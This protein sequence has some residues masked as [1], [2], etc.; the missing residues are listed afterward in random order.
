MR[1]Q[2]QQLINLFRDH[3]KVS[4]NKLPTL[5]VVVASLFEIE[6]S[7]GNLESAVREAR[8]GG[9]FVDQVAKQTGVTIRV[10]SGA[11]EASGAINVAVVRCDAG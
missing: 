6:R 8:N 4:H 5:A 11:E 3:G 9:E 1:S 7:L 2:S 10:I